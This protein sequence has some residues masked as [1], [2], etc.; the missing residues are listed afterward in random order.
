MKYLAVFAA[1]V[2]CVV[3]YAQ[4]PN[5]QEPD[6]SAH[7][8]EGVVVGYSQENRVGQ[9]LLKPSTDYADPFC[10]ICGLGSS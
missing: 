6:L 2:F 4:Q 10:V 8:V 3:G 7:K 9:I 5:S 1:L